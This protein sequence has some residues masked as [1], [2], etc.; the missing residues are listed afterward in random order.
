MDQWSFW[1][2]EGRCRLSYSRITEQ[3]KR[4]NKTLL[5]TQHMVAAANPVISP[6]SRAWRGFILIDHRLHN[7]EDMSHD[8]NYTISCVGNVLVQPGGPGLSL[9]RRWT[10]QPRMTLFCEG[11]AWYWL[12]LPIGCQELFCELEKLLAFLCDELLSAHCGTFPSRSLQT[13][14]C[15]ATL[16]IQK[17]KQPTKSPLLHNQ[18]CHPVRGK[19]GYIYNT[20]CLSFSVHCLPMEAGTF[21]WKKTVSI[22]SINSECIDWCNN[23]NTTFVFPLKTGSDCLCCYQHQS[24]ATQYIA[25]LLLSQ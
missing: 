5:Q 8:N 10:S 19:L 2:S 3:D 23:T 17:Q 25:I 18:H 6:Q 13:C 21:C 22:L 15:P 7:D 12:L 20:A 9:E 24:A 14:C 4:E 11:L 16:I 1:W